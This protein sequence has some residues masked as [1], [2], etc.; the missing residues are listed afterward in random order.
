MPVYKRPGSET[1]SYDFQFKGSRYSGNTGCTTKREAE[2]FEERERQKAKSE[3]RP[4]GQPMTVGEATGRYFEEVGKFHANADTTLYVMAWLDRELGKS[5]L[6]ESINDADIARLISKRRAGKKPPSPATIN[7]SVVQPM[8]ALLTRAGDIWKQN[9]QKISWKT[10]MLKEPQERVRE[11]MADEE[12]RLFAALREDYHPLVR[13][14]L[15]TGCRMQECLDLE[16]R[17]IDWHERELSVTGKGDKTRMIPMTKELYTLLRA[18]PRADAKVFVYA[19]QRADNAPRGKLIPIKREGLKSIFERA[20]TK[21][22]IDNFSFHDLRHTR[23][24]RL[25]RKS[26]NIRLVKELLGHEDLS[27][28]MK[29]AHVTKEDLRAALE[30]EK[31]EAAPGTAR[32]QPW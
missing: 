13:F 19:S 8:R 21:A 3:I 26:G 10:H 31:P 25:L 17:N 32:E 5:R 15:L 16:W 2:K 1:Y 30:D 7:R 22:Q 28:T 4:E 24:T 18:L 12:V 29:Y 23:A 27:T 6:V 14:A 20:V 9:V 11:L